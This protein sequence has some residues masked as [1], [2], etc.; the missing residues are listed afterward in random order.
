MLG[1]FSRLLNWDPPPHT[2]ASVYPPSVPGEGA[3]VYLLAGEGLGGQ[4]GQGD[5]QC[6]TLG[7]YVLCDTGTV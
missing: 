6:D 5:R 7:I 1:F 4:F 2:Q 3:E